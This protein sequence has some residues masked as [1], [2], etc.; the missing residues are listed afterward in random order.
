MCPGLP[1]CGLQPTKPLTPTDG[2][3]ASRH[4]TWKQAVSS[5]PSEASGFHSSLPMLKRPVPSFSTIGTLCLL[6]YIG[7][8]LRG[9][10]KGS[11]RRSARLGAHSILAILLAGL[12]VGLTNFLAAKTCSGMG[13]FRNQKLHLK[14]ANLPGASSLAARS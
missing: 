12:A 11:Q 8:H 7:I 5:L 14:P 2:S 6:A 1:L 13:F 3:N 10:A 9:M 4:H